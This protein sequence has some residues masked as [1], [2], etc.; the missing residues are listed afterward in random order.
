MVEEEKIDK[1]N[2]YKYMDSLDSKVDQVFADF[3]GSSFRIR[4]S[5]LCECI[6]LYM[7]YSIIANEIL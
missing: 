2:V 7:I 6:S 1:R 3:S 5:I 4:T